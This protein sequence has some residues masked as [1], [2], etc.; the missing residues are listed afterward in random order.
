MGTFFVALGVSICSKA[1]LGVSM[2]AAP[3]FVISEA[4]SEAVPFFS[5]GV[6]S[7]IIQGGLLLLLCVVL[8]RFNWRFLLAFASA[9]IYGYTLDLL[10]WLLGDFSVDTVWARWLMLLIGNSISAFGVACFFRTY[11]P[12]QVFELFVA[13]WA[14]KFGTSVGKTKWGFD[15]SLLAVSIL[16]ASTLFGDVTSFDWSSIYRC[17]F[18]N[19]G[20]GTIVTALIN[21][22]IITLSG[23][24]LD[25]LFVNTPLSPKLYNFLKI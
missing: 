6:T 20:L 7:Y 3:A 11:L 10:L 9:V 5:T 8:R 21:S 2:I 1:G 23:K 24:L 12:L 18:H 22:P 14:K 13:E 17:A 25:K 4:V 15:L 19:V 16:L